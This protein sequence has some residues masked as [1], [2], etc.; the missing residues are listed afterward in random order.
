MKPSMMNNERH[1][2]PCRG[3][4]LYARP[5]TD[6]PTQQQEAHR[7]AAAALSRQQ[8]HSRCTTPSKVNIGLPTFLS[9]VTTQLCGAEGRILPLAELQHTTELRALQ[10]A[11]VQP[12]WRKL[13]GSACTAEPH[14]RLLGMHVLQDSKCTSWRRAASS[15]STSARMEDSST[16]Q[17]MR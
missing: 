16:R 10:Q 3:H 8:E 12:R 7:N 9:I 6:D 4:F 1:V 15:W 5:S 17:G 2:T 11:L 14:A 13:L